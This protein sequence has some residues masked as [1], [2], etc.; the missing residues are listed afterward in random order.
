MAL[1]L[2]SF[3][4]ALGYIRLIIILYRAITLLCFA[5]PCF[6]LRSFGFC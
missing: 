3:G 4:F 5:C 2:V 1:S 6:V